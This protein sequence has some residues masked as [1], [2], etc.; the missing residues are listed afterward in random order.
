[1]IE[2]IFSMEKEREKKNSCR[3]LRVGKL[4]KSGCVGYFIVVVVVRK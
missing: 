3:I 4:K 1:M 2:G